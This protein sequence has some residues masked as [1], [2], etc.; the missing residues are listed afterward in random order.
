MKLT[1][2]QQI[3]HKLL[4]HSSIGQDTGL[5]YGK[6]GLIIFLMHYAEQTQKWY[7]ET[8]AGELIKELT[9]EIHTGLPIGF[10][11]GLS[12]TG[13]GIEYLIQNGFME[14]NSLDICEAIDKKIMEPDPRRMT[15]LSLDTGL[16]GILHYVLAHIKGVMAQHAT[17]PFDE[18]Y[19]S[20]LHRAVSTISANDKASEELKRLAALYSRFYENRTTVDY[21]MSLSFIIEDME[22]VT[23]DK[24]N[25]YPLGLKKGLSGFLLKQVMENQV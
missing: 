23:E 24:L 20:D 1:L 21:S 18:T 15:D 3:L 19:L 11:S 13:W 10:S 22:E 17:L 8:I 2:E 5:Y 7:Y 14:G 4:L 12:G 6:T 16:E 9:G 25:F